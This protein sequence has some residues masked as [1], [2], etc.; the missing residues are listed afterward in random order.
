MLEIV[1]KILDCF[2]EL[3]CRYKEFKGEDDDVQKEYDKK[4]GS[5][6]NIGNEKGIEEIG[7][8]DDVKN[9]VMNLS[10][11]E[12]SVEINN[13]N[14]EKESKFNVEYNKEIFN[15]D[16]V[17]DKTIKFVNEKDDFN[18]KIKNIFSMDIKK[19][20]QNE[21]LNDVELL[22]INEK[23][24]INVKDICKIVNFY[25]KKE[26]YNTMNMINILK[27][28]LVEVDFL[29]LISVMLGDKIYLDIHKINRVVVEYIVGNIKTE[30]NVQIKQPFQDKIEKNE[31]FNEKFSDK[32]FNLIDMTSSHFGDIDYKH[33][34]KN[35]NNFNYY[36]YQYQD[37]KFTENM[38]NENENKREN[39]TFIPENYNVDTLDDD[40]GEVSYYE[41]PRG[42]FRNQDDIYKS[43]EEKNNEDIFSSIRMSDMINKDETYN[44]SLNLKGRPFIFESVRSNEE[45]VD[46]IMG[47]MIRSETKEDEGLSQSSFYNGPIAVLNNKIQGSTNFNLP[48]RPGKK[49]CSAETLDV[50]R[51]FICSHSGCNSAF[52]R[53][54]HLKRHY[55]IHTGERPYKCKYPGCNRSFARS[56]NLSQHSKIHGGNIPKRKCLRRFI[57]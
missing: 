53:F 48:P 35:V 20:E 1:D 45:M 8:I 50:E 51:P 36:D 42:K 22:F 40:N 14:G 16:T 57:E 29:A 9:D 38:S 12:G 10:K 4:N 5:D 18:D 11:R 54:E 46:S 39:K 17:A 2:D 33:T 32:N 47:C 55:R 30:F 28:N 15:T 56:D 7:I 41:N 3:K 25:I 44:E 19:E 26:F 34:N 43:R 21:I 23:L 52:K 31:D 37:H 13:E 24:S 49:P 6:N 27:E